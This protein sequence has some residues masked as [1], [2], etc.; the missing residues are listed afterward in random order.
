V[1]YTLVEFQMS[2]GQLIALHRTE[3]RGNYEAR[4][5]FAI[6]IYRNISDKGAPNYAVPLYEEDFTKAQDHLQLGDKALTERLPIRMYE[7]AEWWELA[8][9][10][11]Y[12]PLIRNAD[13]E[14]EADA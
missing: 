7:Q 4:P 1:S 2:P 3:G 12:L 9:P 14:L 5:V 13:G 8:Q 10:I 11:G 6:G